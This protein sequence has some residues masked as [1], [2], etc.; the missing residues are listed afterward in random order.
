MTKKKRKF[1]VRFQRSSP[2]L[3]CALLATIVLSLVTILLLQGAISGKKDEYDQN[4]ANAAELEQ[5]NQELKKSIA[6]LGTVQSI[7]H[8][9]SKYL[10]LVD[11]DTIFFEPVK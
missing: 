3:K 9:A 6:E 10:D 1:A 2:L 7:K 11:P 8:I 4:R 5:E